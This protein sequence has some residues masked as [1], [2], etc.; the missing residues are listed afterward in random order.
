M[1]KIGDLKPIHSTEALGK[2]TDISEL[3]DSALMDSV[4]KPRDGRMVTINSNTGGLVDG[5][6]RVTELQ[7]RAADPNSAITPD[8]EIPVETYKP[9]LS[10]FPDLK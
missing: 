6:T 4:T 3:S 10:E 7:K 9:D 8:T 2:R 1:E 5:N